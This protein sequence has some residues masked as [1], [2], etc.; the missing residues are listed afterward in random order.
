[1]N[2]RGHERRVS[3]VDTYDVTPLAHLQVLEGMEIQSDAGGDITDSY[4]LFRC[5]H[6]KTKE[7]D[8]ICCGEPT[9]RDFSELI[10]TELPRLFNP[11]GGD[12][13]IGP[14]GNNG[15]GE[16]RWNQERK[17]LYNAVMLFIMWR[18]NRPHRVLFSI[19]NELAQNVHICP[20]LSIVKSVNTLYE[21]YETTAHNMV[22]ELSTQNKMRNFEFNLL[23]R[24]LQQNGIVQ[25]FE[26]E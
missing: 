11:L 21:R 10:P 4:F 9:A 22:I 26:N 1:M 8:M 18:R 25:H 5:I 7:E 14:E 2:C 17:Q 23:T 16:E 19:A 13:N 3:I 15:R 6:K 24:R 12:G 20:T